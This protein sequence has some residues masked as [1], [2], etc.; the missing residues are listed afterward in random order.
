[1]A[2]EAS[3][4]GQRILVV[5]DDYYLATDTVRAL[6]EAGASVVGPCAAEPDARAAIAGAAITG[7][8]LDINLREGRSFDLAREFKAAG[9]PFLFITGYDQEVIPP[10]F[11]TIACLQKPV[12]LRRVVATLA[13]AL[14][15]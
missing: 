5:E 11:V 14:G 7:A 8:V 13:K 15:A 6:K 1:M 9:T 3:L 12:E 2:N 4:R 10:E